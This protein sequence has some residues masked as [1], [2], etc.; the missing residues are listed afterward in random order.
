MPKKK[1]KTH[2]HS[3][4]SLTFCGKV[5][6]G[7]TGSPLNRDGTVSPDR[8]FSTEENRVTCATCLKALAK[9]KRTV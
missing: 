3:Q 5:I 6:D 8:I 4:G 1:L 7:I 2:L 9:A